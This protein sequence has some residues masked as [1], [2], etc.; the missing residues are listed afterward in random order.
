MKAI[1]YILAIGLSGTAAFFNYKNM[2]KHKLQ[3]ERTDFWQEEDSKQRKRIAYLDGDRHGDEQDP[4]DEFK[5]AVDPVKKQ[6]LQYHRLLAANEGVPEKDQ[7]E[8]YRV[9]ASDALDLRIG[10]SRDEILDKH[11]RKTEATIDLETDQLR[12]QKQKLEELNNQIVEQE[13]KIKK[14]QNLIKQIEDAFGALNVTID[15]VPG[16]IKKLQDDL[17]DRKNELD[18]LITNIDNATEKLNGNKKNIADFKQRQNERAVRL[19]GNLKKSPV[20][21]V[22][23]DWGFAVVK[24]SENLG[25]KIDDELIIIRG[26]EMLGRIKVSAVEKGRIIGDIDY[27]SLKAGKSIRAGDLAIIEK[28]RSR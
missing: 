14:T 20:A 26:N 3:I 22:D 24:T 6:G 17:K 15:E 25:L 9:I 11:T 18:I 13:A 27:D 7:D 23:L 8:N 28:P 12:G 21:A 4:S 2:G 10:Y 16:Y 5:A 1:F 19:S